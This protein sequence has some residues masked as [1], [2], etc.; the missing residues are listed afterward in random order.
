MSF[1]DSARN[2]PPDTSPPSWRSN[3]RSRPPGPAVIGFGPGGSRSCGSSPATCRRSTRPPR[4]PRP[5]C[6]RASPA[7]PA[8]PVFPGRDRRA[9]WTRQTPDP[10]L[11]AATYRTLIGLLAVTGMRM[12]EACRLDRDDVD[13]PAGTIVIPDSKFGKS[14][15][16]PLHPTAITA[17]PPTSS[18]RPGSPSP[19]GHVLRVQPRQPLDSTTYP[20]HFHRLSH[21]RHPAPPGSRPPA[22]RPA[23]HFRGRHPAGLVPRRR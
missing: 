1:V 20:A 9:A 13:L 14:R 6:C 21:G 12:G 23:A 17:L 5:T 4:S 19:G 7:D 3:G 22:A 16:V 10:P 18:P 11:R 2:A 15:L 8:L